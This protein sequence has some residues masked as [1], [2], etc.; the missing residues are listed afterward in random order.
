M[1]ITSHLLRTFFSNAGLAHT[2]R[3]LDVG[4]GSG[5]D[6][7]ALAEAGYSVEAIDTNQDAIERFSPI[8]KKFSIRILFS[9]VRDFVI[10]EETYALILASNVLFF[11]SER[12]VV[13]QNIEKCITGLS[14]GGFLLFSLLGPRDAWAEKG[15]VSTF[16][17]EEVVQFLE[18]KGVTF[19]FRSTEEGFSPTMKGEIK[20]WHIHRF[21][22]QK[23]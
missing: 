21:I 20:Y 7:R 13:F 16:D 6:A 19:Y 11:I 10:T 15:K 23:R 18:Q 14:P 5:T 12:S 1:P 22:M 8:A 3:A 2:G 4:F 17:F 9:D